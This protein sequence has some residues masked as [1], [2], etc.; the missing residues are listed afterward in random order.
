MM[1]T[2]QG[3][4]AQRA[5]YLSGNQTLL[6]CIYKPRGDGPFPAV[7]FNQHGTR[8]FNGPT[9]DPFPELAKLYNDRG[10]VLFIPGRHATQQTEDSESEKDSGVA[11]NIAAQGKKV[12][13][14]HQ[15]HVE[16]ITASVQWLR[17]QAYVDEK[18]IVMTGQGAGGIATLLVA[19]KGL[20]IR[21]FVA[22]SP[23]TT[24]WGKYPVM[25]RRL[26]DAVKG[27]SAPI[28]VLTPKNEV[29]TTSTTALGKDLEKK[30][31][32]NRAKV[33]PPF[34]RNVK[35][36]QVFAVQGTKAWGKD[37]LA[38]IDEVLR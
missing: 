11:S 29:N 13:E 26:R 1:G 37:V 27:A 38:F 17:S 18:Q 10:Y 19:E 21:G 8:S 9:L 4:E 34:G 31:E 35:E 25:Q 7:I 6:G 24:S 20:S 23:A 16:N 33:Y 12:M 22:F 32:P 15:V 36:A 30:G 28:F 2:L 5:I 14:N 3:A